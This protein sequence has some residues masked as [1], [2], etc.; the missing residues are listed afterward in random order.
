[1]KVQLI[2]DLHFEYLEDAC[3][4]E[5]VDASIDFA[6][7]VIPSAPILLIAGDVATYDCPM[8]PTFLKWA[9]SKFQHVFWVLGNHEFYNTKR[10]SMKSVKSLLQAMCPSNVRILDNE[11]AVVED[12][13]IIGSTL[14]SHVPDKYSEKV[15]STI[16]DYRYIFNENGSVITVAD[17]NQLYDESVAFIKEALRKN[18]NKYS[19]VVTHHSPSLSD[20]LHPNYCGSPLNHAFATDIDLASDEKPEVWCFG[21]THYNVKHDKCSRG[22]ML[23]S[24]QFGY[25]GE[26]DGCLYKFAYVI[27]VGESPHYS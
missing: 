6:V 9:G 12:I 23:A 18:K 11:T 25:E 26:H 4:G 2:S 27:D 20:T 17:T 10:V 7:L 5:D 22:Y 21:H 8:L 3:D 24:N 16:S 1:M 19:I 15:Q 14:W 13:L